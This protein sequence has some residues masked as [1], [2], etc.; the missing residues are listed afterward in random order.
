MTADSEAVLAGFAAALYSTVSADELATVEDTEQFLIAYSH[1]R[2]RDFT[3]GELERSWAAGVWTRAYDAK[4]Q[5]TV[6]QPITSL[7]ENEAGERLRRT[8]MP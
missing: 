4:D 5:H 3:S 2:G 6:G 7:S 1:A 8:G